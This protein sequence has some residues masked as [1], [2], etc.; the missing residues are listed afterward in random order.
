MDNKSTFCQIHT[1]IYLKEKFCTTIFPY[2]PSWFILNNYQFHVTLF[3]SCCISIFLKHSALDLSSL[4]ARIDAIILVPGRSALV[5]GIA[6]D[7]D[8]HRMPHGNE[9]WYGVGCRL[10]TDACK[11][12]ASHKL[13]PSLCAGSLSTRC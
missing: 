7:A 5:A 6:A 13:D 2:L 1:Q 10:A 3:M 11:L 12:A 9:C 4:A 8:K